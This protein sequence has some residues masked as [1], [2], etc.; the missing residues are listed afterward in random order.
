MKAACKRSV[1][2]YAD[3]VTGLFSDVLGKKLYVLLHLHDVADA[4]LLR[5]ERIQQRPRPM[6]IHSTIE[7]QP[8]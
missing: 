8:L 6:R 4:M 1:I 3:I 2:I 7:L 5:Q